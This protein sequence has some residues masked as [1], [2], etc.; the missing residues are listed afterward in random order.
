MASHRIISVVTVLLVA[1]AAC[2]DGEPEFSFSVNL[3]SAP[4]AIELPDQRGVPLT[5]LELLPG[6]VVSLNGEQIEELGGQDRPELRAALALVRAGLPGDPATWILGGPGDLPGLLVLADR[7]APLEQVSEVLSYLS[8]KRVEFRHLFF[9]VTEGAGKN[10]KVVEALLPSD[11]GISHYFATK[12][13]STIAWARGEGAPGGSQVMHLDR[14]QIVH[15]TTI[16]AS[17]TNASF[18]LAD[19]P[20]RVLSTVGELREWL[21]RAAGSKYVVGMDPLEGA[22]WQD[23]ITVMDQSTDASLSVVGEYSLPTR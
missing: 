20:E 13:D 23:F 18:P 7:D 5:V 15:G 16:T 1:L 4:H 12:S 22:T 8:W 14:R 10:V 2:A 6:G 19:A 9:G 3:P 17:D 21:G 11:A